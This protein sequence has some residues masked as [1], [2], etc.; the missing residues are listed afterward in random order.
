MLRF[1]EGFDGFDINA[2]TS[3]Q[4]YFKYDNVYCDS[5]II[6]VKNDNP[7]L[8]GNNYLRS[9]DGATYR[10]HKYWNPAV[11][12]TTQYIFGFAIQI[13]SN[14][15]LA[16]KVG[17]YSNDYKNVY[18]DFEYSSTYD[19]FRP[20]VVVL[21]DLSGSVD[22]KPQTFDMVQNTWYYVEFKLDI[23]EVAAGNY[24]VDCIIKL[25]GNEIVNQNDV[26]INSYY[27]PNLLHFNKFIMEFVNECYLDDI[28]FL[29]GDGPQNNDF[30]GD[31]H[32]RTLKPNAN[33]SHNDFTPVGATN[34]W[35][36]VGS[37]PP[38]DNT[39][40]QGSTAGEYDLYN[41]QD[42]PASDTEVYGVINRVRC[43]KL[44][45]GYRSFKL[46]INDGSTTA[47]DGQE[48]YLHNAIEKYE[49]VYEINPLTGNPF[50][51]AELNN[52]Q[53]GLTISQ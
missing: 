3:D 40:N 50:T 25:D 46:L 18:M 10:L 30:L 42:L 37:T 12:V 5:G 31:I 1:C 53:F 9:R 52:M 20:R 43:R 4:F 29:T 21:A 32:V 8:G 16:Y 41:F 33:G 47:T 15:N 26:G 17:A 24:T 51:P 22:F 45:N 28:Y 49:R 7:R 14:G 6:E 11:E 19:R 35:E 39:Y 48:N 34:N 27:G 36:A 23:S 38:D 13:K 2:S 44:G